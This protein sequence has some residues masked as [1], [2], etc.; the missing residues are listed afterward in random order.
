MPTLTSARVVPDTSRDGNTMDLG[1]SGKRALVT[2]GTRGIGR[3]TVELLAAEG[4]VLDLAHELCAGPFAVDVDL[5][6]GDPHPQVAGRE[7]ADEHHRARGLAD[8]DEATGACQTV[9]ESAHIHVA[10]HV[11][12]C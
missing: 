2:G 1:I 9:V 6:V 8:V 10:L 4:A 7:G 5:A 12:L 3:A 11:H